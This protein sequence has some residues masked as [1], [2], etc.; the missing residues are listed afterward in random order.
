MSFQAQ[1]QNHPEANKFILKTFV[2]NKFK[3]IEVDLNQD[4]KADRIET[5]D[6]EDLISLA[7]DL[8]FS[9]KFDEWITYFTFASAK[10]P[11]EIIKKDTNADGQVDRIETIYKDIDHD[12]LIVN[13]EV[14]SKF[15]GKF[16][17]QFTTHSKLF[18]KKDKITCIANENIDDLKILKL[19]EDVGK[20]KMSLEGGFYKTNWGYKIHQ[21]CLDKWGA[22]TFISLL[23]SSMAQGFQCLGNLAK[24]NEKNKLSPNGALNNLKGLDYLISTNSIS[25]VCNEKNYNGDGFVGH[26]ST[27]PRDAIAESGIKHPFISLNETNPQKKNESNGQWE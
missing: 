20:V 1:S 9:G 3:K 18:Q 6:G 2:E 22:D 11:I 24:D 17:K 10:K 5:Y 13:T 16:D 15:S 21:S 8:K 25:I 12:L 23:K 4:G 7:R 14:D 26:A 19:T 27:S